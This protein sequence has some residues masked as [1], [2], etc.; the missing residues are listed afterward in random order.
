MARG[1]KPKPSK[2]KKLAGNPGKRKLKAAPA[3]VSVVPD[4]PGELNE[5][6]REEW[7]RITREL[8]PLG[9]ITRIDR[10]ALALYCA[11]WS[12]WCEAT[13]EIRKNGLCVKSPNGYLIQNPYLAIA[14]AAAK[15]MRGLLSELGLSPAARERLTIE[16]PGE[17][18]SEFDKFLNSK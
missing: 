14:N 2:V 12:T 7:D 16:K 4:C 1:R 13:N 6:G 5:D 10:A 17:S 15:E 18:Q 3:P 9:L 11:A 8:L